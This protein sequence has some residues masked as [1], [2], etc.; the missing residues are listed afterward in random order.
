ML[1]IIPMKI[2]R[3][4]GVGRYFSKSRSEEKMKTRNRGSASAMFDS[5]KIDTWVS[6]SAIED[7][8]C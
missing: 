8:A 1:V 3:V 4:A 5:R 6:R 7:C 2:P